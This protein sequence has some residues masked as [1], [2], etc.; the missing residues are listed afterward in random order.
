[1]PHSIDTAL[2]SSTSCSGIIF[3]FDKWRLKV[4]KIYSHMMHKTHIFPLHRITLFH[5]TWH[6]LCSNLS[7]PEWHQRNKTQPR[8]LLHEH[9]QTMLSHSVWKNRV[10]WRGLK[11]F[12]F[13]YFFEPSP[14][15]P[16]SLLSPRAIHI[17]ILTYIDYLMCLCLVSFRT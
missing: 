5:Q 14:H 4:P 10:W 2:G 3:I 13:L 8:S 9:N 7:L 1:M 6:T 15:T 17:I 12:Y 16:F 11:A